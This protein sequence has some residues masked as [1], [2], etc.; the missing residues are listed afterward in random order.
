MQGD[1]VGRFLFSS[2]LTRS[3]DGFLGLSLAAYFTRHF[4]VHFSAHRR[5]GNANAISSIRTTNL[6]SDA[7]IETTD[8][9]GPCCKSHLAS[10]LRKAGSD[11]STSSVIGKTQKEGC[12]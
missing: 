8:R 11:E 9:D 1:R 10:V 6:L 2:W 3:S 7:G 4:S 5:Y 12:T